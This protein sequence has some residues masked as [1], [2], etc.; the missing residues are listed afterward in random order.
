MVSLAPKNAVVPLSL[1]LSF[2]G[3]AALYLLLA[4]GLVALEPQA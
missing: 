2:V 1:P 4:V 3:L